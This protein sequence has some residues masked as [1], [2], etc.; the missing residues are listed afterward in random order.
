[1]K[2]PDDKFQ[3]L[4]SGFDLAERMLDRCGESPPVA[5]LAALAE[6]GAGAS[7]PRRLKAEAEYETILQEVDRGPP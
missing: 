7:M 2:I 6:I 3:N 5:S 4:I 1:M